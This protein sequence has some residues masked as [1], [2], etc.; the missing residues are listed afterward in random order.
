[1]VKVTPKQFV[2]ETESLIRA[3]DEKEALQFRLLH[4]KLRRAYRNSDKVRQFVDMMT[5][6]AVQRDRL[7]SAFS[8]F[9]NFTR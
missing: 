2:N 4:L 3:L 8:Q 9:D 7:S 1:M 5:Q 6:M